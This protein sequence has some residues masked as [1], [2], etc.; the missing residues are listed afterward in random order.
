[1]VWAASA[2]HTMQCFGAH[3]T[4]L[5]FF[6]APLLLFF[7]RRATVPRYAIAL[8]ATVALMIYEGAT[9]PAPFCAVMLAVDAAVRCLREPRRAFA[10]VGHGVLAACTAVGL[11][12]PRI[13]PLVSQMRAAPRVIEPD[14]DTLTAA[15]VRVMYTE[16]QTAWTTRI[17]GQQYSW[18]EYN[19]YVGILI[20]LIAAAGIVLTLRRTFA[21]FA[22]AAVM[23][24][25]ML[26]HFAEWAP[27]ALLHKYVP[28]FTS[29]RV[30]SRFRLMLHTWICLFLAKGIDALPSALSTFGV[31]LRASRGLVVAVALLGV[32]EVL[33]LSAD[34]VARRYVFQ[35]PSAVVPVSP[36]LHFG[37]TELLDF[38][39]QPQQNQMWSECRNFGWKTKQGAPT[40]VGDVAQARIASGKAALRSSSRTPSSFRAVL[41]VE[42]S[43]LVEFNTASWAGWRTNAG[44]VDSTRE[45]VAVRLE[46]GHHELVVRYVPVNFF[47]GIAVALATLVLIGVYAARKRIRV[48]WTKRFVRVA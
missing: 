8:G 40:W 42:E 28:P 30:P 12:A 21:E 9:Y 16:K 33:G 38:I 41:D 43:T 22:V 4:F 19:A 6:F 15:F 31:P 27:W 34:Q 44:V 5:P 29:M 1:M 20:L 35:A 10:V 7:A 48:L 17:P 46:P 25:F 39:D 3:Y 26:G 13:L 11:A 45:L 47:E 18:H 24:S 37:T 23:F 36:R 32:G 14:L 2:A